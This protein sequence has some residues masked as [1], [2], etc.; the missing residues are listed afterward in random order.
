[1]ISLI[2]KMSSGEN[3][4]LGHK[5][6]DLKKSQILFKKEKSL[7]FTNYKLLKIKTVF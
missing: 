1:M 4:V 5:L 6:S 2:E 7:C 3:Y